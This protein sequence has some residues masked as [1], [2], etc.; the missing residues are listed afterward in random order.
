VCARGRWQLSGRRRPLTGE[1]GYSLVELLAA[2][3]LTMVLAAIAVPTGLSHIEDHH[4]HAAARYLAA[5]CF[6]ARA[7]AIKRSTFVAIRFD[8][9]PSGDYAFQTYRD[10]NGNGVRSREIDAGI[11]LPISIR[12][13]LGDHFQGIRFGV[14]RGLTAIVASETLAEGDDPVQIGRSN[15]LSFNPDGSATS[16]TL[17]VRSERGQRAVRVLGAT[18]RTRHLTYWFPERRWIEQ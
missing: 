6:S 17:Y 14:A 9:L 18:G 10:G 15:L 11:D 13:R 4:L 12:E 7:E 3:A 16:G 1:R 8:M 5:R 2:V